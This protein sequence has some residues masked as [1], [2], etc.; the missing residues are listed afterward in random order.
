MV[1]MP[2]ASPFSGS[3]SSLMMLSIRVASRFIVAT[4]SLA[5]AVASA[6][7]FTDA[8][9]ACTAPGSAAS[10]SVCACSTEST[11][12]TTL[13]TPGIFATNARYG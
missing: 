13:S 8:L 5:P 6:R 9:S 2:G 3:S 1:R 7:F 4:V 11:P 10:A 12:R